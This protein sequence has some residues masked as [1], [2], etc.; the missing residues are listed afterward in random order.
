VKKINEKDYLTIS[1]RIHA[2]ENRL[3]TRE[4]MDRLMEVGSTEEAARVLSECGYPELSELNLGGIE[5]M[6]AAARNELRKD[7]RESAP[8]P[9]VVDLFFLPNDY[10]NVKVLLKASATG[11]DAD[12][13]FID[14]GRYSAAQLKEEIL[15][16][17][18]QNE[19]AVFAQAVAAAAKA[20]D[21]DGSPQAADQILDR[22]CYAEMLDMA[23]ETG[24]AF[25]EGYVRLSIDCVNLRTTVRCRRIDCGP[26]Y[27]KSALLPG[28]TIDCGEFLSVAAGTLDLKDLIGHG[29]PAETVSS[30]RTG[31]TDDG[32]MQFE[33]FC[34]RVL[35][36]YFAKAKN[37]SFGEQSLIGY[38]YAKL[39]E[40][41]TVRVILT[42]R[43]AGLDAE[44]IRERLG[45]L[46]AG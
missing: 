3:L 15:Q 18:L 38:L 6:L 46:Y 10:H 23:Q 34:S 25:L 35:K 39:S 45:D 1:A 14:C 2:M 42:G 26:D 17:T 43:L 4:R 40:F 44:A 20:L 33:R 9:A 13:L 29:F 16:G 12:R 37:A 19:T 21:Q 41:T 28:G 36:A 31:L 11:Q 7:L 32:L 8:D 24:S 5:R 22:A 30:D 27:L